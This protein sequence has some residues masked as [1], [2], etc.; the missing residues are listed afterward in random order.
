MLINLRNAMM[1]GKR[2]PTAKDYLKF[3]P[4]AIWDG[5]EN[6]GW[7]VHDANATAWQELI[8][9][10]MSDAFSSTETVEDN[11][12]ITTTRHL[13]LINNVESLANTFST[14]TIQRVAQ[15][16]TQSAYNAAACAVRFC[17]KRFGACMY[18]RHVPEANENGY[19]YGP[20]GYIFAP[21]FGSF[22]KGF[23]NS[24]ATYPLQSRTMT[25]GANNNPISAY[26]GT[27][28]LPAWGQALRWGS[29]DTDVSARIDLGTQN[30]R[31]RNC[32]IRIFPR[33]LTESEIAELYAIDKVRFG[34]P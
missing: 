2:T 12:I 7:G 34:L 15:E 33:Q 30:G 24:S 28:Q 9:G 31:Y 22:G 32:S 19:G 18:F 8:S 16:V 11:A 10:T 20:M 23:Y 4:I 3:N 21:Y 29:G 5:I 26:D 17:S 6:A 1:S 13:T 27:S 14:L 25:V